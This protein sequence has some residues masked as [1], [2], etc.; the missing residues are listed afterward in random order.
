MMPLLFLIALLVILIAVA[1]L[2]ESARLRHDSERVPPPGRLVDLGGYRLHLICSGDGS[3]AV[4]LDAGLGDSSLVWAEV[5]RKMAET[6]RL[7]SYDRAGIGWSD[8]IR[9]GE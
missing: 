2:A 5:Q 1:A 6:T 9:Q 3:P 8:S 4:V 7:C